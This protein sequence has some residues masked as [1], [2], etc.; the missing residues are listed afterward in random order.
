MTAEWK[1][2]SM[3]NYA[4]NSSLLE[5][6]VP[7]S[8]ELDAFEGKIYLSLVG[9]EFNRS[10]VSGLTVLF[11]QAF[12]EVNLRFYVK[13]SGKRGVVFISE[14]VPKFAV[15]A[16]ARLAYK[17]KYLCV[18]MAHRI[19]THTEGHITSAEYTW[20][21]GQNRCSMRIETEGASYL[22]PDGSLSQFIT[23]HYWGYSA[24][25]DGGS[26]EYEVQHP[27]WSVRNSKRAV[28]SGNPVGIYG[29][30]FAQVLTRDPDSAFVAEGSPVTIFKGSRTK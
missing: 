19:E 17:E 15:A 27:Q 20:G 29:A 21:S 24:Q 12:E 11:H 14:F 23:E 22:P 30:D 28:F 25:P 10:R 1:N 3:F 4:V 13:R 9:F 18:P 5:P 16:V 8:T 26:V 2:L 7:S 6:F